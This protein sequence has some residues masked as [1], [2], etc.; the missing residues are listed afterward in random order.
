MARERTDLL[1]YTDL[2]G[3][4]LDYEGYSWKPASEALRRLRS[5]GG[6]V[7]FC[8]SKTLAELEYHQTDMDLS[9]P[10]IVENGSAIVMPQGERPTDIGETL[11]GAITYTDWYDVVVLGTDRDSILEALDEIR[12]ESAISFRGYADMSIDEVVAL[13]GL[14]PD[15]ARRARM[16]EFSETVQ[17]EGGE[18]AWQSFTDAL[19]AWS[20]TTWG[21]GPTGTVVGAGAGKGRAV[22]LLT[23]WCR[24]AAPLMTAGLG[25]GPNDEPMLASVDRAFLVERRGGG[26]TDMA[27][28]GLVR[29]EGVGPIGWARAVERILAEVAEP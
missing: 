7:V 22:R 1:V 13:T 3:T 29:V 11:A 28:E 20:L 26:W 12:L 15:A 6:R 16:R 14:R 23:E 19:A 18:E 4:L 25:D 17:V 5:A 10:M 21:K 27:V 9:G 24:R 8:S 2:D